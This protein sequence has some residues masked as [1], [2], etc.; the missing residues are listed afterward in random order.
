M[1]VSLALVT[2]N[3]P[4]IVVESCRN[5][6]ETGIVSEVVWV[7]NASDD[8]AREQIGE[9]LRSFKDVDVVA[10]RNTENEGAARGLN[11]AFSLCSGDAILVTDGDITYPP[12]GLAMMRD[13]L[14][15]RPNR[16][17]VSMY[18]FP[19]ETTT[20][21]WQDVLEVDV[22]PSGQMTA[23]VK[24]IP[25]ISRMF[26]RSLLSVAGYMR[27]DFGLCEWDDVEWAYRAYHHAREA[28]MACYAIA[29]MQSTHLPDVGRVESPEYKAAKK[30]EFSDPS[31]R[32]R[33]VEARN[34]GWPKFFPSYVERPQ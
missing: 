18:C 4:E 1:R 27:E 3:R 33:V 15:S 31:K 16:A 25:M 7:D 5:V 22:L 30:A 23:I 11:R 9:C 20:D 24:A 29:S 12:G 34:A 8:A 32:R 6:L 26:R 17:A 14:S 19:P 13:V 2:W 10:W 21:R 28:G